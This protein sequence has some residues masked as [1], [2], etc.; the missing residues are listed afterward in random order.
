MPRNYDTTS[1]KP[2]P[3][4]TEITIRYTTSRI[5]S[6]EYVEQM[7]ILDGNG[8]VQHLDASTSRHVL[9]LN[10]I[11]EPVQVVDP[12]TGQPI[13]NQTVTQQQIMLGLLAFLRAD[14]NKRDI[15][16]DPVEATE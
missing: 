12:A 7:A 5:P 15:A 6:I 9:D 10:K 8:N 1:H 13:A 3:R 16:N 14:Q 11:T 2:Y 4:I